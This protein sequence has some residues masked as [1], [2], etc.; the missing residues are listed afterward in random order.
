MLVD[1]S[2]VI[3]AGTVVLTTDILTIFAV[4]LLLIVVLFR[5]LSTK[6]D[7]PVKKLQ[8]RHKPIACVFNSSRNSYAMFESI[9]LNQII[10]PAQTP[11]SAKRQKLSVNINVFQPSIGNTAANQ[12]IISFLHTARPVIVICGISKSQKTQYDAK[13]QQ[14]PNHFYPVRRLLVREQ[15]LQQQIV[16]PNR[17]SRFDMR[18]RVSPDFC[19]ALSN[20]QSDTYYMLCYDNVLLQC[21]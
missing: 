14:D 7:E 8:H 1:A 2:N 6:N 18:S 15:N 5:Q 11:A 13:Q 4:S 17:R 20:T 16:Q 12:Y 21:K 9:K 10:L 3:A 19:L